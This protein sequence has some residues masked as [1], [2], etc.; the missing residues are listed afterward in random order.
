VWQQGRI[1]TPSCHCLG[2]VLTHCVQLCST[3]DA[4][5]MPVQRSLISLMST[6]L[7]S[8]L[9]WLLADM[10]VDDWLTITVT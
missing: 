9:K 6:A 5:N 3:A 7:V 2:I 8:K 1:T 4:H 10:A